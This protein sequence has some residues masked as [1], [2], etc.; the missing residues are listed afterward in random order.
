MTF[1]KQLLKIIDEDVMERQILTMRETYLEQV[2]AI[3]KASF[4]DPW[5][6][7]AFTAEF[8][9]PWSRFLVIGE[10][11]G[12]GFIQEVEG[13]IICWM[14]AESGRVDGGDLHLLNLAVLPER[15]RSG[16]AKILLQ[17]VIDDFAEV[18]GGT[19]SLEVRSSNK[20]AKALYMSSGFSVVGLRQGYY[21]KEN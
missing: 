2:L 8:S 20:V 19:I 3:E 11:Q 15:R 13:F 16:V 1:R 10:K 4:K 18:G 14:F 17:K 21:R 6:R 5:P 12:V 9:H 7:A